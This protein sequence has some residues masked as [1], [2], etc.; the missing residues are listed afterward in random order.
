V[1]GVVEWAAAV[2]LVDLTNAADAPLRGRA[3]DAGTQATMVA[4]SRD[5]VGVVVGM[6]QTT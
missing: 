5:G 2:D 6:T 1:A 4:S 3:G